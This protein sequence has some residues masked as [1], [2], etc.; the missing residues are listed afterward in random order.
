MYNETICRL[1]RSNKA[2]ST[3]VLESF[4]SVPVTNNPSLF[5]F[6]LE[7]FKEILHPDAFTLLYLHLNISGSIYYHCNQRGVLM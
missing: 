7:Q 1:S 3:D 2:N 6:I 4:E 5:L